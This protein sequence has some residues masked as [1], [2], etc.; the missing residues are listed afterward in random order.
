MNVR[1]GATIN[2][3]WVGFD[4][5]VIAE[6]APP[7][8]RQECRR[9]FYAGAWAALQLLMA[10]AGEDV[11]DEQGAALLNGWLAECE[12]FAADVKAGRK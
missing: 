3:A 10:A 6:D 2:D 5:A 1:D 8:R 7:V 12:A 4:S 9:S 11:P